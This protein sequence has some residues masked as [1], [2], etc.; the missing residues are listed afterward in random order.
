MNLLT[1]LILPQI[2]IVYFYFCRSIQSPTAC[3]S[4]IQIVYFYFC[5]YRAGLTT[6]NWRSDET[7]GVILCILRTKQTSPLGLGEQEKT[8]GMAMYQM[9]RSKLDS[10][11][12]GE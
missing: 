8:E 6:L 5:R 4:Q 7:P 11:K 3:A 9:W 10:K 12:E 1:F 2:Q